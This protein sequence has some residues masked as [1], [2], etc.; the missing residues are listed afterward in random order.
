M[1]FR[2]LTIW[3]GMACFPL[4]KSPGSSRVR[5]MWLFP[6]QVTVLESCFCYVCGCNV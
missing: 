4:H 5:G 2:E 3:R 1:Y 6:G